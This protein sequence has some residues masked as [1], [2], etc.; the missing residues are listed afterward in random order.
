MIALRDEKFVWRRIRVLDPMW[1]ANCSKK[2][3]E[4]LF[5]NKIMFYGTDKEQALQY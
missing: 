1:L 3:I 5:F 4:C 2:D